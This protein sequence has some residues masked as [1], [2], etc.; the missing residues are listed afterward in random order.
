M[1]R[2]FPRSY[3]VEND[4]L[5]V[6]LP[7]L[8]RHAPS[9]VGVRALEQYLKSIAVY[10]PE[11]SSNHTVGIEVSVECVPVLGAEDITIPDPAA[12]SEFCPTEDVATFDYALDLL[13]L[14]MGDGDTALGPEYCTFGIADPQAPN[15]SGKRGH[16][17]Q[18]RKR[19]QYGNDKQRPQRNTFNH[20]IIVPYFP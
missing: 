7:R 12:D 15:V 19:A 6:T 18:S 1:Q 17:R 4:K 5:S 13:T 20:Q 14:L 11:Q 2:G 9:P 16:A 8:R 10:G 3:L